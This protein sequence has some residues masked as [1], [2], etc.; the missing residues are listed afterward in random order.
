MRQLLFGAILL[1]C[2]LLAGFFSGIESGMRA[3][4]HA[5]LLL[6][7]KRGV[8]PAK[9]LQNHLRDMQRFLATVLVGNNLAH[10]T[11]SVLS[12][13]LAKDLFAGFPHPALGESLWGIAMAAAVLYFCEY[14]PK[15]L[16]SNRPL[17]RTV[18][19]CRVF[20]FAAVLLAPFTRLTLWITQWLA[21]TNDRSG[22]AKP[23]L[24]SRE[25]FVNVVT[26]R[27]KGADLTALE[28]VLIRKVLDLEKVKAADI[29]TPT[30]LV[31]K[32]SEETPLSV[33]FQLARDS[34]HIRLPIV[35]ADGTQWTGMVD[36]FKELLD[37][38]TPDSDKP[39][40]AC[41]RQG[42]F[43]R[44]D[45][46]ADNLLPMMRR[47]RCPMLFVRNPSTGETLGVITEATILDSF[48]Q[49]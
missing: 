32:V 10:V 21:L 47:K 35:S 22:G 5:R 13:S 3:L 24:L 15:L 42:F 40:K 38:A 36:V 12:A 30:R 9:T 31:T 46:P 33:C 29:M 6:W 19:A 1:V 27:N 7:V 20:D 45:E 34:G 49:T 44:H 18:Q 26:D 41:K 28:S 8:K 11:L 48:N 43:V 17:R 39:A 25:Y 4:N 14:I 16:F 2:M 23:F 37:G